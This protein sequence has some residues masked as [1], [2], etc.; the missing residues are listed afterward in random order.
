MSEICPLL[1]IA[2]KESGFISDLEEKQAR[3]LKEECAWFV[4]SEDQGKAGCAIKLL[5]ESLHF[6]KPKATLE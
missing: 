2:V 1:M 4:V 3:C 5:T 6:E